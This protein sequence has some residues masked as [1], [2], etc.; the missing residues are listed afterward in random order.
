MALH[1]EDITHAITGAAKGAVK[2]EGATFLN[3]IATGADG[4]VYV[5][6]SGFADGFAPSG[7]DAIHRINA[8][9]TTSVVAKG[10]TLGHPNGLLVGADGLT[11]VTFGSGEVYTLNADGQR[12]AGVKT[13]KGALDGVVA[14]ETGELLISSWGASGVYRGP[15]AGPFTLVAT[16]VDAP[17]DI[18]WDAK[19]RHLLVPLFKTNMVQIHQL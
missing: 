10:D 16:D 14:L 6:D 17:A 5:S 15:A 1:D 12:D 9:G 8:D 7:T 11:V 13:E 4:A 19:R 3:D 2:I 18:G